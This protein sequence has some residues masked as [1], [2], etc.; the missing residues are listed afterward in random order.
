MMR[1]E[2][3]GKL[4][5]LS[6]LIGTETCDLLPCSRVPQPSTLPCAPSLLQYTVYVNPMLFFFRVNS[7]EEK[8]EALLWQSWC[9]NLSARL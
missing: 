7:Q 1:L 8:L 2:G 6:D 3:L 9:R 5:N 4:K